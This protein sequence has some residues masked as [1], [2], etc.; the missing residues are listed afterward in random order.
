MGSLHLDKAQTFFS[1]AGNHGFDQGGFSRS[2][3]PGEQHIV[4]FLSCCKNGRIVK[5]GCFL[6]LVA[7][8]V[9]IVVMGKIGNTDKEAVFIKAKG[10]KF[11]KRPDP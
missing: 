3:G 4:T 2:P 9:P 8:K 11:R 10:V 6:R 7:Q 1:K 5:E